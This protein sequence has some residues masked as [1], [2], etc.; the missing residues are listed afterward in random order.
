METTAV[1]AAVACVESSAMV[2]REE[3]TEMAVAAGG[4][5]AGACPEA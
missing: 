2:S 3:L 1:I 4:Q 5:Y